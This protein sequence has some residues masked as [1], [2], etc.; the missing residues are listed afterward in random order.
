MRPQTV[1]CGALLGAAVAPTAAEATYSPPLTRV[2]IDRDQLSHTPNL[3]YASERKTTAATDLRLSGWGAQY[4][5]QL[6]LDF[7]FGLQLGAAVGYA[8]VDGTVGELAFGGLDVET[9]GLWVGGQL[10]VYQMLWK[11]SVDEAVERPSAITAFVNLRTLYYDTSGDGSGE[12]ANLQFFTLTGGAGAMAEISVHDYV[13]LCPYAWITPGVTATLDYRVRGRDFDAD[14]GVTLRNPLLVGLD[15][16][17]YPFPP[18]WQ[19][20]L[21]LSFLASLIDTEGD[22]RTIAAVLGYTF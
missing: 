13:S 8:G 21:S 1:L 5:G 16:W 17:I 4:I 10:R 19:D 6:E 2:R 18:N 22:D 20:H 12:Q 11:S 14:L 9:S 3:V 7:G 15:V